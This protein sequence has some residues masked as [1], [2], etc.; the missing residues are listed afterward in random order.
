M[1]PS[2]KKARMQHMR[3]A[4]RENNV[5]RWAGS[6]IGELCEMRIEPRESPGEESRALAAR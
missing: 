2:E 4:V 6:L 1:E 5:Y 3:R